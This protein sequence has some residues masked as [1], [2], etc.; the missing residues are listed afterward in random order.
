MFRLRPYSPECLLAAGIGSLLLIWLSIVPAA[1]NVFPE[2]P[3][4]TW[5]VE[6]A[7][8]AAPVLVQGPD[9]E[10]VAAA[11]REVDGVILHELAII[12]AVAA[13]LTPEQC[14]ALAGRNAVSRIYED[15]RFRAH[16]ATLEQQAERSR[17]RTAN[18]PA[19]PVG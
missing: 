2:E 16:P 9:L 17:D 8:P 19:D 7:G 13:E 18:D 5:S 10:A 1:R 3:T 6:T 14:E 15:R 11:V 4:A 12:R